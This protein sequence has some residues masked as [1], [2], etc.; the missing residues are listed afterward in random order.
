M[1]AAK[2]HGWGAGPVVIHC[3]YI[4]D[5]MPAAQEDAMRGQMMKWGNSLAVRIPRPIATEA[6]LKEGDT[7]EIQVATEGT[8]QLHR[9]GTVPTL[10]QL[11]Q[12]ITPENR[13][14]EIG[15]GPEVG[16]EAVEW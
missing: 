14:E 8:V 16:K 4:R 2:W 1:G 15:T 7:L 10:A 6:K 5:E 11:V 9:V 13:Y 12:K 3:I